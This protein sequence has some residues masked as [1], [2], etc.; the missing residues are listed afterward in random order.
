M[1]DS[2]MARGQGHGLSPAGKPQ[3]SYEHGTFQS[4]LRQLYEVTHNATYLDYIRTGIDN[5][6]Q[7]D[8]TIGANYTITKY[9]LDDIRLG[10]SMIKLYHQTGD[11]KYKIAADTF[12]KQ[13]NEQPR[14]TEGGLFHMLKYANQ[15]WLDGLYMAQ[16]FLAL[17]AR[18][19]ED[20]NSTALFD[21]EHQFN[22]IWQHCRDDKTGLLRH[23]YFD[24][25]SSSAVPK[26]ADPVS[27]ASPEV[28]IRAVGWYVV[29]LVDLLAPPDNVPV[30]HPVYATLLAQLRTLVTALVGTAD[31][32]TGGW[33]LVMTQPGRAGNYIESSGSSMFIYS[34][35]KA[36]SAGLIDDADGSIVQTAR[37]AYEYL[38]DTFVIVNDDGTLNWNGTVIVGS[39]DNGDYNAYIERRI[40]MNDVKG[41]APF[42]LASIEYEKL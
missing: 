34:M 14:N 22:L 19:F 33:W 8:G 30:E 5:V 4:A 39:L 38:G 10:P 29:A 25:A 17:Y 7:P 3:A 42:V 11:V 2:V 6:V 13:L 12:R 37:R 40:N 28:W 18:D 27:G 15:M 24:L 23:G 20:N 31:S 26:W 32:A 36:V 1:A 16:P 41:S 21:I 35:L 9:V